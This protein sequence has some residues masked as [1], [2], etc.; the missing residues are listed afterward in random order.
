MLNIDIGGEKHKR[1]FG[2]KWK[3]L[4][5]AKN[6]DYVF[7]LNS[8]KSLPFI[9]NFID[10]IY[11]SHVLEHIKPENI[12]L[13]LKEIY[14]VL[15]IEGICR[16]VVP[17]FLYGLKL[18]M[19]NPKELFNKKYCSISKGIP[20]TPMGRLTSWVYSSNKTQTGHKIGFD[21][22]LLRA[23]FKLTKFKVKKMKYNHCSNIFKGKDYKRYSGW[24]LYFE[25]TKGKGI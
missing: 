6:S 21:E 1:T 9:D 25:L 15:K 17:D 3:T 23:F 8:K 18:Y 24:C 5:I 10:N 11:C 20:N 14:R 4:D 2:N 12:T 16:I 19:N 7:D 13:I 22:E